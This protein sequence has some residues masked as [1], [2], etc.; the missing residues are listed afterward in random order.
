MLVAGLVFTLGAAAQVMPPAEPANISPVK[1]VLR[2]YVDSGAY[3]KS[4][5]EVALEANKYLVKRIAKG[6]KGGKKLAIVF[7]IDETT[8]S[9]LTQILAHDFG[10][11]EKDWNAWVAAGRAP[12]IIPVQTV[13]DTAVRGKVEVF[14]I[15]GR[16]EEDRSA[17]ERNLRD[18]GYDT[19]TKVFFKPSAAEEPD[20]TTKGFKI[21]TRRKLEQQGYVIIANV[22]DQ[23]SDLLG[24]YAERW[25][26]LPNPFY[27][28]K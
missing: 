17:T 22:G 7:D 3:A 6:A 28:T 1:Q 14:F 20:L 27:I 11:V 25:F 26:K 24:G 16:R 8:L 9:N 10:Y 15:T 18:V 4:I 21:D 23:D 2:T 13:Y 19:W 5:A 12:A